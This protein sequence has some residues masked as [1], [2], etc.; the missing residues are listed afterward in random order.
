MLIRDHK[1]LNRNKRASQSAG[2]GSYARRSH[3]EGELQTDTSLHPAPDGHRRV[4]HVPFDIE[5]GLK[6][7]GRISMHFSFVS[8]L[9]ALLTRG[10]V[11]SKQGRDEEVSQILLFVIQALNGNLERSF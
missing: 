6:E 3:R 8:L 2:K 5:G 7:R 9:T 10:V 4:L 11:R 1:H